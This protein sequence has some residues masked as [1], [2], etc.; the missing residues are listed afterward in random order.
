[1]NIDSAEFLVKSTMNLSRST[2]Q[3]N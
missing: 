1:M 3:Q 2:I